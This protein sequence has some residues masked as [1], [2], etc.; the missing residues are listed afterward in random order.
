MQTTIPDFSKFTPAFFEAEFPK[1]LAQARA[2]IEDLSRLS[3]SPTF[4][5]F[6]I[7]LERA[8]TELDELALGF[9]NLLHAET[10]EGL[11]K[12]SEKIL[13]E[14]ARFSSEI[15]LNPELFA[16]LNQI[17]ATQASLN[18]TVEQKTLLDRYHRNFVQNGALLTGAPRE[19]IKVIDERM[20]LIA[21]KFGDNVLKST[22]AWKLHLT[23]PDLKGLPDWYRQMI[24]NEKAGK[25]ILTL[26]QPI[27]LGFMKFSEK[28]ELRH[29]IWF[30]FASRGMA[31]EFDNTEVLK[32]IVALRHER[33]KLLGSKTH[34]HFVLKERMA[35][36]PERAIAFLDGLMAASKDK[37]RAEVVELEKFAKTFTADAGGLDAE[38]P[39]LM[40]WDLAFF[41]EKLKAKK[42]AFNEEELK[43]YLPLPRMMEGIFELARML[44]GIKFEHDPT[45][46]VYHAEVQGY[47]V[48]EESG[49]AIGVLYFDLHPRPSKRPGAWMTQFRE[50]DEENRPIVSIVASLSRGIGDK[51]ALLD[52]NEVRTLFHEFGHALHGLLSKVSYRSIAGTNVFW[53]FVELPSQLH[54]NWVRTPEA[55]AHFGRHFETGA[56][57]PAALLEKLKGVNRFLAGYQSLR[58]LNFCF[59]DFAWHAAIPE[60]VLSGQESVEAF[61]KKTV[62]DLAPFPHQAGT[63]LSLGFSHLFSGGYSAGYYSY[64]W[65]EVLDA[66]AFEAFQEKGLFDR[67]VAARFKREILERGGSE[68]PAT[69]YRRFRG[70]DADPKALLR[71]DGLV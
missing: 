60:S 44:Y 65:A 45:L 41:S 42:F 15:F 52:L 43:P 54:E 63:S 38:N 46:P 39:H 31:P 24:F 68:H 34:A 58:Q 23:E 53:D 61:E 37:A 64:K 32:E 16:R 33:A 12:L 36:T 66:D 71:R 2:R 4:K 35:E 49:A 10:N 55:L 29:K 57:I 22:Q 21:Q 48:S 1:A 69:L 59:L 51:P 27:Y 67:E 56:K 40:P 5:N 50:Q 30:A 13:P 18:L 25:W 70:R 6:L 47:R 26:D 11:Q 14:L 17:V 62:R 19:R 20:S 3:A 8:S 28:R 7:P 9:S